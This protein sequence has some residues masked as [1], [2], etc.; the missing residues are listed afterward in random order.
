[1]KK[2]KDWELLTDF[3]RSRPEAY[4]ETPNKTY[5]AKII[6][7]LEKSVWEKDVMEVQIRKLA[8]NMDVKA[9]ELFMAI[10]DAITGKKATPPILETMI[11][12]GKT[13]SLSRLQSLIP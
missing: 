8:Q 10:R 11:V 13:E 9:G 7:V 5:L 12:L 6:P 1:M 3:F 2:L 4:E